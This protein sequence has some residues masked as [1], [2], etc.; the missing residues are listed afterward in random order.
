VAVPVHLTKTFT[1]RLPPSMRQTARVGSRVVVQLGAKPTVGYIV[2]LQ[3]KLRS[4]T[5]LI[6][7][8]I[9]D[10]QDLL[11]VDPP[12]SSEVLEITRWVADYYATP[13]GEVMRAALPA[14]INA[15]VEQTISI[16]SRG[17]A[18]LPDLKEQVKS[19]ALTMLAHEGEFELAAFLLRLSVAQIPKWLREMESAG[20][21]ARSYKTRNTGTRAQR[22]RSVRLL[23]RIA[24]DSPTTK[25]TQAQ[26]RALAALEENQKVMSV[27]DLASAA[28]VS[29]S[30]VRTL[31][32]KGLVEEFQEEVRRD[33]LARAV[34]PQA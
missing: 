6:E 33:P 27:T 17:L 9:K 3:E 31:A 10:V 24:T 1:Y 22:R 18:A 13:L 12:L 28:N 30:V 25:I 26:K 21:I 23:D 29:E 2:A 5:S 15:T 4:E 14:G 16:T 32:R 11:D 34:L 7:S 8:K 19:R 20:L